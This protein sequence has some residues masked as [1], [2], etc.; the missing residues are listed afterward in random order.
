MKYIIIIV[1]S[2][3]TFQITNASDFKGAR[4]DNSFLNSKNSDFKKGKNAL[5]KATKY[6]KKNKTKKANNHFEKAIKYFV[7]AHKDEPNNIEIL[8][9]L[10]LSYYKIGDLFM[11]E[12]YYSEGL[13]M[14]PTNNFINQE[15]GKLYF[16]TKRINLAKK[17]LEVLFSCNCK[18][19]LD[20]L[21][22]IEK[23]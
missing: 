2:I 8:K 19:Y 16:E 20:L 14:D 22:I 17:R 6:E 10:G 7:S 23:N 15:L 1:L 9:N 12:I 4:D 13:V 21:N 11:S 18:E 5:K 3:L